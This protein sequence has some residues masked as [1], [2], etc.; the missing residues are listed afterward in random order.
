VKRAHLG[1]YSIAQRGAWVN[2]CED[3]VRI[4]FDPTSAPWTCPQAGAN[5]AIVNGDGWTNLEEYI[6]S[7][8]R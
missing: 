1:T 2:D 5:L 8:A 4:G 7:L 3:A 6:N